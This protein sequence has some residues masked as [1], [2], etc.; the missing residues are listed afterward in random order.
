M[1][2][3]IFLYTHFSVVGTAVNPLLRSA[4]LS[5]RNRPFANGKTTVTLVLPWLEAAE[6]RIALYGEDW[7][8]ATPDD[9][10]KYIR[11]WLCHSANLPLEADVSKGG[12]EI[13]FYPARYHA[14]LSSIFAMGDLCQLIPEETSKKM[15]CV[16]E[17]PEHVN[18][19]RAPGRES[20]REKL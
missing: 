1:L 2:Y 10:N 6:D 5:Q 20:W 19:Y 14:G 4:Y 9:Q 8:D 17:E 18:F 11:D 7:K 15:I 13:H 16:L 3:T 12:I